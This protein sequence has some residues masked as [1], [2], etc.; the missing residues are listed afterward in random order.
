LRVSKS[1]VHFHFWVNYPLKTSTWT[2]ARKNEGDEFICPPRTLRLFL[3]SMVHLMKSLNKSN[4]YLVKRK[5]QTANTLTTTLKKKK[6][7]KRYFA[8]HWGSTLRYKGKKVL[9]RTFKVKICTFKVLICTFKVL[10][11]T[12]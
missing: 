11:W 5:T 7:K 1:W 12:I 8:C 2:L 3:R 4:S 10:I 6:K 9:I